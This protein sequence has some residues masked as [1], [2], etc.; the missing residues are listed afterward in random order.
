MHWMSVRA[1]LWATTDGNVYITTVPKHRPHLFHNPCHVVSLG[2]YLA[3]GE[4]RW[5]LHC[6]QQQA[7]RGEA[8]T[9][10]ANNGHIFVPHA[11]TLTSCTAGRVQQTK[12]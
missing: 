12:H 4:G 5:V 2:S 7:Q 9:T 11:H 10:E 6:S 8:N 3:Q 1:Y